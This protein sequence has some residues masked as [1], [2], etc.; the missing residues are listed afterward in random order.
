MTTNTTTNTS[1]AHPPL[2]PC[3]LQ[4]SAMC[5][6]QPAREPSVWAKAKGMQID[7]VTAGVVGVLIIVGTIQGLRR[8]VK[9]ADD[10]DAE[11]R[12][13]REARSRAL[14][15]IVHPGTKPM[16]EAEV[17]RIHNMDSF[18][19]NLSRTATR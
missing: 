4:P 1:M 19:G 10:A 16:P 15:A 17:A 14:N 11:E 13:A 3:A 9:L 12:A 6:V 8:L 5:T 2:Q 7:P 18:R